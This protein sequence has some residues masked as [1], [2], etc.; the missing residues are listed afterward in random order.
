MHNSFG[1]AA[2]SLL[3]Q[4][5]RVLSFFSLTSLCPKRQPPELS[6]F[7]FIYLFLTSEDISGQKRITVCVFGDV[8]SIQVFLCVPS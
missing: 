5:E 4:S 8:W 3:S 2:F 6:L 1:V 7:L